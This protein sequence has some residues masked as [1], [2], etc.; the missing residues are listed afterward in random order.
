MRLQDWLEY[1]ENLEKS[2]VDK[3]TRGEQLEEGVEKKQTTTT[4]AEAAASKPTITPMRNADPPGAKQTA[5][6]SVQTTPQIAGPV[7]S[8]QPETQTVRP[9][10]QAA[11]AESVTTT[12]PKAERPIS[13]GKTRTKPSAE[14]MTLRIP[15]I[16]DYLPFL[17]SDEPEIAVAS[18]AVMKT[19]EKPSVAEKPVDIQQAAQPM[20]KPHSTETA[21]DLKTRTCTASKPAPDVPKPEMAA[22]PAGPEQQDTPT[23][24][25]KI[26]AVSDARW[27]RLPRHIRTLA[28]MGQEE[29]AQ[30]S[31][32]RGFRETRNDLLERLL[33]PPLTLEDAARILNVCPTTVRRYTNKGVLPHFRTVGNQR[34]FRLS[35]IIAF[36]EASGPRGGSGKQPEQITAAGE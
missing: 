33:D 18:S 9:A 2:Q 4:A 11:S 23:A 29:I 30:R 20:Q 22:R 34:R 24:A 27:E 10:A 28:T 5:K 7:R 14:D 16:E 3:P 8:T 1:I 26:P 6:P 31:Y 35:D 13:E 32:K 19:E 36:M 12:P 17:R 15:E 25:A 21:A